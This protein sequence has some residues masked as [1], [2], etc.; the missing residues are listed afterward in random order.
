MH[1]LYHVYIAHAAYKQDISLVIKIRGIVIME[2]N[3]NDHSSESINAISMHL[4]YSI[5][6]C[7][8]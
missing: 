8:T 6:G 2:N 5:V 4:N 1:A 3:K 7:E